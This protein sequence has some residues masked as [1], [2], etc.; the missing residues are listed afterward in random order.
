MTALL[1]PCTWA[2]QSST[3]GLDAESSDNSRDAPALSIKRESGV[4]PPTPASGFSSSEHAYSS[5]GEGCGRAGTGRRAVGVRAV[6][7]RAR[8]TGRLQMSAK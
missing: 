1:I 8:W 5:G 7:G 2:P 4:D 6:S 3:G